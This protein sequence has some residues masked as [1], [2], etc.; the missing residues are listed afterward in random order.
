LA[1]TLTLA[2]LFLSACSS[3]AATDNEQVSEKDKIVIRFS[4]VVGE[5]TPKGQAV[6]MFAKL[7]KERTNGKVE[8][9]VFSN[10]SLYK[11][12]EELDALHQ[13][14][15]QMIAPALSKLSNVV[16]ELGIFDLPYLYPDL[17]GYHKVFDGKIGTLLSDSVAKHNMVPLGYWDSGLKQFTTNL[18]PIRKPADLNGSSMRIMPSTI[19]DHQFNLLQVKPV[20]TDFNDVYAALEQGRIQGQENTISNIYSKKF[21]QV[22]RYMTLSDHGYL[23]YLVLIDQKFWNRLPEDVRVTLKDTM[24]EVTR[25]QRQQSIKIE[26]DKLKEIEKCNCI[27]TIKLS[28]DDKAEWRKYF[29]PLYNDMEKRLGSGLFRELQ[30]RPW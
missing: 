16:P 25:W 28:A 20:Q 2:L 30:L 8:I 29:Q 11:D 14:R 13:G 26:Q 5:D 22:Q 27:Q 1:G 6:R 15:V 9:Q 12:S 4:H 7:M 19:L 3:P 24:D 18:R 10:S 21:Y 17:D 23:G